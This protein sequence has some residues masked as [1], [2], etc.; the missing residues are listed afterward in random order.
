MSTPTDE[1]ITPYVSE[2][3]ADT[4]PWQSWMGSMNKIKSK[5]SG[6]PS[7]SFSNVSRPT[8]PATVS[9]ARV[10]IADESSE[11]EKSE[12]S[13][14]SSW[15]QIHPEDVVGNNK[16]RG[17]R[18]IRSPGASGR[19]QLTPHSKQA[20]ARSVF[21]GRAVAA[22]ITKQTS[23]ALANLQALTIDALVPSTCAPPLVQTS[24]SVPFP[25]SANRI[26]TIHNSFVGTSHQ[27]HSPL[28]TEILRKRLLRRIELRVLTEPE[29]ESIQLLATRPP[30]PRNVD[31]RKLPAA[32]ETYEDSKAVGGGWSKGMKRWA[33]RPCFEERVVVWKPHAA[34]LSIAPVQRDARCSV[35]ALE[36]SEGA[37]ALAGLHRQNELP[38]PP[39]GKHSA[40]TEWLQKY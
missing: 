29:Q 32:E 18:A 16:S 13:T 27:Q 22:P 19:R 2:T 28:H 14:A 31:R 21:G 33:M 10:S 3:G 37:E 35:A 23:K 11:D 20:Q 4:K 39:S 8:V 40:G 36:F 24:S 26:Q 17:R 15:E 5:N 34:G 25:R 1:Q 9:L 7:S 6:L 12:E 38:P 30:R